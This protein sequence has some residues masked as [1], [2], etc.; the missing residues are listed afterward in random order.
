MKASHMPG[1]VSAIFDDENVVSH[2]GLV[3]VMELAQAAG[4]SVLAQQ[5]RLGP[6]PG[7]RAAGANPAAKIPTIVAAMAAGA[8][9]IDDIA[10]LRHGG[11]PRLFEGARAPSTC[12]T[13]L[14]HM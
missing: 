4:L 9:C 5:V 8:D 7:R 13:F 2:G 10:V 6:S 11:L 12:G 3:P 14:R 1:A